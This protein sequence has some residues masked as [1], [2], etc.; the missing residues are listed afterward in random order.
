MTKKTTHGDTEM[1]LETDSNYAD[2]THQMF[3]PLATTNQMYSPFNNSNGRFISGASRGAE[4]SNTKIDFKTHVENLQTEDM[5]RRK[6][7]LLKK[8]STRT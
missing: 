4:S 8:R 2:R 7:E 5:D 3:S 6:Q 1:K